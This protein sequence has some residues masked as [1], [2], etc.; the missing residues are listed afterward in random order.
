MSKYVLIIASALLVLALSAHFLSGQ[1]TG[2][3]QAQE[4]TEWLAESLKEIQTIKVGMTRSDLLKIFTTEGGLSTGLNRTFV[5]RGCSFIK[6]DV[7]FEPFGRATRDRE[8]RV[9]LVESDK[10]VITKISKPYLDWSVV[11]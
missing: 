11:D 8:G 5:F 7:E 9:T 2:R 4:H 3:S 10:D 1:S 6:V